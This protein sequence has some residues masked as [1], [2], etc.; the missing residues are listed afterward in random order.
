AAAAGPVWQG[1]DVIGRVSRRAWAAA[2]PLL[3]VALLL[4]LPVWLGHHTFYINIASQILLW[5]VA[6]LALNVLVGYAGLVSL[7]HAGLLAV[8][9]YTVGVRAH[10]EGRAHT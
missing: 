5:A 3:G 7:G 1:D 4:T 8:A 6:A 10:R 2:A 9:A